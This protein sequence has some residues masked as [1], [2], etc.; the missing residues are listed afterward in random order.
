M[1]G[2][3]REATW[4][5][6]SMSGN[7]PC[8]T[9]WARVSQRGLA[10]QH[11]QDQRT[12]PAEPRVHQSHQ[13]PRALERPPH[14]ER[15]AASH[16]ARHSTRRAKHPTTGT[17]RSKTGAATPQ[18]RPEGPH[19]LRGPTTRR[20]GRK[21][22]LSHQAH[23][24][25]PACGELGVTGQRR[26]QVRQDPTHAGTPRI[27][28]P[29]RLR[30]QAGRH[31]CLA[32]RGTHPAPC[33]GQAHQ[34]PA[35]PSPAH[36]PSPHHHHRS[37]RPQGS[38]RNHTGRSP[39]PSAPQGSTALLH[40]CPRRKRRIPRPSR[41]RSQ[42]TRPHRQGTRRRQ[43]V[44][45][46]AHRPLRLHPLQP[47]AIHSP[48]RQPAPRRRMDRPPRPA[49]GRTTRRDRARGRPPRRSRGA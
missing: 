15:A 29:P 19:E 3:R 26:P 27:P 12:G 1:P 16:R 46:D 8:S 35:E 28:H 21:R 13:T 44:L 38:A 11:V 48:R 40:H 25:R 23:R 31:P 7:R 5:R 22:W 42:R 24:I 17:A 2:E 49:S 34:T 39:T 45:M 36:H 32:P 20:T 43:E 4:N 37:T 6:P 10:G 18:S 47:P 9:G 41:T 14:R 33:A 30:N